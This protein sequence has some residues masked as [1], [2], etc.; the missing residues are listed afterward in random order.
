MKIFLA[1]FSCVVV[2][3]LCLSSLSH[4]TENR[5]VTKIQNEIKS[6]QSKNESAV[7]DVTLVEHGPFPGQLQPL[8][9]KRSFFVNFMMTG[10]T[11]NIFLLVCGEGG[12]DVRSLF[13]QQLAE[14]GKQRQV[15]KIWSPI[16][17]KACKLLQER[18]RLYNLPEW[19][20]QN[21]LQRWCFSSPY[22]YQLLE[23]FRCYNTK[24]N[25]FANPNGPATTAHDLQTYIRQNGLVLKF[26]VAFLDNHWRIVSQGVRIT[27]Q[28]NNTRALRYYYFDY[29][30]DP[31]GK[32]VK[33]IPLIRV[34]IKDPTKEL[35]KENLEEAWRGIEKYMGCSEQ[36]FPGLV[37]IDKKDY[38]K[39]IYHIS[40]T[41]KLDLLAWGSFRQKIYKTLNIEL[42]GSY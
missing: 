1:V 3:K 12:G 32:I 38:V 30:L 6:S 40:Q 15:L 27:P 2:S 9:W 42:Q 21:L 23:T 11:Y 26:P 29:Y 5:K 36:I 24:N 17:S 34:K 41:I 8:G 18:D 4:Q 7:N 28:I 14:P 19:F 25:I 20:F 31:D 35:L 37:K 22:G 16:A 33:N 13:Y 10:D 39:N